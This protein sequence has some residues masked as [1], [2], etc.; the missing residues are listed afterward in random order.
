MNCPRCLCDFE[1]ASG[2]GRK[3]RFC[4]QSCLSSYWVRQRQEKNGWVAVDYTFVCKQCKQE[5]TQRI[6]GARL[7][8]GVIAFCGFSCRSKWQTANKVGTAGLTNQERLEKLISKHGESEGK[9]KFDEWRVNAFSPAN[10]AKGRQTRVKNG[11]YRHSK[12]ERSVRDALASIFGEDLVEWPS[13]I[14]GWEIDLK[15]KEPTIYVQVDGVFWHGLDRSVEAI[16]LSDKPIDRVILDTRAR[17][18]EQVLWFENQNIR[19]VRI[20]D[21]EA[22]RELAQNNLVQYL[23]NKLDVKI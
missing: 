17:D 3:L 16:Q 12:I 21:L 11:T 22:Q 14:N 4:S 20:T 9:A 5:T 6:N 2:I 13:R 10:Y 1:D 7:S 8:A 15:I 23:R 19:L 18:Q